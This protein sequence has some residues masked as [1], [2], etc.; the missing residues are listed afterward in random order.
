MNGP[1][2]QHIAKS[3]LPVELLRSAPREVRLTG[4]GRF[5]VATA[6]L[7]VVGAIVF[8]VAM[9]E[10]A[11]DATD[12]QR[13][14][15]DEGRV[16]TAS[17]L[18]SRTTRGKNPRRIVEYEFPADGR[19][20]RTEARLNARRSQ[21]L[22]VGSTV[23]VRYLP[24][25]P[26]T[27]WIEGHAPKGVPLAVI[28]IGVIGMLGGAWAIW[29]SL[30]RQRRLVEEGRATLARVKS[31]RPVRKGDKRVQRVVYEFTLMSGAKREGRADMYRKVPSEGEL[32]PILYD[33]DDER[34]Q[35]RYPTEL[36]RA[37]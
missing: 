30:R 24:A 19:V 27:S 17:V 12:L 26:E 1:R 11:R 35:L 20:I 6:I 18:S 3:A 10:T 7:L 36:Y 37:T 22:V 23:P 33:K 15:A 13:R 9:Y 28:P 31:V 32:I 29:W 16:T 14:M 34:R 25:D 21:H 8:G 2:V 4:L 5:A